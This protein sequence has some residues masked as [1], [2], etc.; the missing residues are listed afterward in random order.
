MTAKGEA[1]MVIGSFLDKKSLFRP[2]SH[3]IIF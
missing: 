3:G 1:P 2:F